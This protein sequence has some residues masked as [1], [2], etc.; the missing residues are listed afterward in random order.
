VEK[1]VNH[2]AHEVHEEK[3]FVETAFTARVIADTVYICLNS[4]VRFV[5]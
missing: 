3:Q 4:F 1:A 5:V 2:E